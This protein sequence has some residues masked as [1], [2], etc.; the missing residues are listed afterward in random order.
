M[1]IAACS[2]ATRNAQAVPATAPTSSDCTRKPGRLKSRCVPGS[3]FSQGLKTWRAATPQEQM[4]QTPKRCAHR[5]HIILPMKHDT[6]ETNQIKKSCWR[7]K[8]PQ[9]QHTRQWPPN[10]AS[11]VTCYARPPGAALKS[12]K[13]AHG[14]VQGPVQSVRQRIS[15]AA[16]AVHSQAL[17]CIIVWIAYSTSLA[18]FARHHSGRLPIGKFWLPSLIRLDV[19]PLF[20]PLFGKKLCHACR[21]DL[22]AEPRFL[23]ILQKCPR[24]LLPPRVL[25]CSCRA[26]CSSGDRPGVAIRGQE[27][28]VGT[29]LSC[30]SWQLPVRL[31]FKPPGTVLKPR[32]VGGDC[33]AGGNARKGKRWWYAPQCGQE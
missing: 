23:G 7:S 10:A 14:H 32:S 17:H 29:R 20:G 13:H 21:Q 15:E 28:L 2:P 5:S 8:Q 18:M 6:R 3:M 19:P 26:T 27:T 25:R 16:R 33:R 1:L 22:L 31:A 24:S 12:G 30:S 11:D 9:L 4:L